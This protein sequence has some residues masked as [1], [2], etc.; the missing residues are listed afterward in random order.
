MD[1]SRQRFRGKR[2]RRK[3]RTPPV[4]RVPPSSSSLEA[5]WGSQARREKKA[6]LA[7]YMPPP[8]SPAPDPSGTPEPDPISA[9]TGH[10]QPLISRWTAWIVPARHSSLMWN[11]QFSFFFLI[12]PVFF[13]EALWN[14]QHSSC[15]AS[16]PPIH[17]VELSKSS[18]KSTK[19]HL[20]KRMLNQH[21]KNVEPTFEKY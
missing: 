11:S 17:L 14:V 16:D 2:N 19:A 15:Y 13:L 4:P 10:A 1:S 6:A 21:F 18:I 5:R 7:F 8:F 9:A 20:L 3:F 12:A